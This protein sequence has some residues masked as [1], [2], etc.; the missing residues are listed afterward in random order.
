MVVGIMVGSGI[1]R[2]PGVVAAQL[3]RP[4]LTFVAWALGGVIALAGALIFAELG[5]RHPRA[6]G[7]YVYVREAFGPR[8]GFVVG[9]VEVGIYAAAIAAIAVAAG[10]YGG[11]L[12]G[13]APPVNRFAGAAA[14]AL[15]TAINLA[16]VAHGRIVQNAVTA[17]KVVAL[18]GVIA[19]ALI[20]GRGAG[21]TE[22]LPAAPTGGAALVALAVAFQ[23]VIWTYYGYPDA[24]KVAEEVIDPDR[25]LPRI[26]LGSIAVTTALYLLLNAAFLH[27]LPLPAIAASNLVAGDVAVAILGARGGAVIA[28]LALLV[29]LASINGNVFVTPRVLFAIARDGLAPGALARVNRGGSPWV[30]MLVVGALAI[31]LAISGTFEQL[32]GLAVTLVF[33][34]DG[35]SALALVRL[36]RRAPGAPFSVPLFPLVAAGFIAVYAALAATAAAANP[37]GAL[38]AG[39]VLAAAALLG[40]ALVPARRA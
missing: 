20:G 8:A 7:K 27:V 30:A 19:V 4:W 34:I 2:T 21:W 12:A 17:A 11:R 6:G 37:T 3:G 14:V 32:L 33:V 16:G 29:V 35:V 22:A 15:F 38:V 39:G 13:W 24:A 26:F 18:V 9:V 5:T 28:A 10:E 1:F 25:T 40:V 36:R 31:A 23:A